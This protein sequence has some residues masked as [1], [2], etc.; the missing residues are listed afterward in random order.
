MLRPWLIPVIGLAALAGGCDGEQSVRITSTSTR[1]NTSGVL[2]VVDTLQCPESIGVL[3]R[4]GS[5]TAGGR[6][7]TYTGP[8]GS[9]VTLHLITLDGEAPD[10]VLNSF[11]QR[12]AADLPHAAAEIRADAA[13]RDAETAAADAEA[14]RADA[15]ASAADASAAAADAAHVR[16]PGI[17]VDT[18]GDDATVR[19]PGLSVETRG[20]HASVRIGPIHISAD[21]SGNG[22][23][24]ATVTATGDDG[25]TVSVNA[26]G[27]AAEVRRRAGGE[28]VRATY[29]L[30][31]DTAAE[32]G[33]RLVGFEARGPAGGPLVVATI[34]TK[35]RRE[36]ASFRAARE[37]VTLNVGD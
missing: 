12:L 1:D 34:R 10:A 26:R 24:A 37:L 9:E 31:S 18:A 13:R 11:E 2:K 20:E 16:A 30:T 21:D 33:W 19:L 14:A 35:A 6:T 5:A 15:E 28:A 23:G 36:D 25:E 22:D 17:R 7:C 3:S 29:I 32:R 27:E 8:K 4:K